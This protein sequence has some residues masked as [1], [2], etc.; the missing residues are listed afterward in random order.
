MDTQEMQRLLNLINELTEKHNSIA[1]EYNQ[2]RLDSY[3]M[4]KRLGFGKAMN[5]PSWEALQENINDL[6]DCLA[7]IKADQERINDEFFALTNGEMLLVNTGYNG[8]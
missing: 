8:D 3:T 2:L 1:R 7:V 4:I 6:A 5:D